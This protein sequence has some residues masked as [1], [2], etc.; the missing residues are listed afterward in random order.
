MGIAWKLWNHM[1]RRIK[2]GGG[3]HTRTVE[4]TCKNYPKWAELLKMTGSFWVNT[5]SQLAKQDVKHKDKRTEVINKFLEL[6]QAGKVDE[7][8]LHLTNSATDLL[9]CRALP[10]PT[11]GN[12]LT[13]G[14][15]AWRR[16]DECRQTLLHILD[17]HLTE[18]YAKML[19]MYYN[20]NTHGL[21]DEKSMREQPWGD[22]ISSFKR[23]HKINELEHGSKFKAAGATPKPPKPQTPTSATPP[24]E[25]CGKCML[26]GITCNPK[27]QHCRK[28]GHQI[29][30]TE[31]HSKNLYR[32][33]RN[34]EICKPATRS[35]G[36]PTYQA[37]PVFHQRPL[38]PPFPHNPRPQ[39]P[40]LP[41]L[42]PIPNPTFNTQNPPRQHPNP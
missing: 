14:D 4:T 24:H 37:A 38:R 27:A 13:E 28:P 21:Q 30:L 26:L 11:N 35:T 6:V 39:T 10:K 12:T 8:T 42:F 15:L 18:V 9:A 29:G 1:F 19:Q 25:A 17:E 2:G 36:A 5:L 41:P 22:L 3:N 7:A 40:P 33:V 23:A 34:C 32:K 16:E 31:P 20:Q